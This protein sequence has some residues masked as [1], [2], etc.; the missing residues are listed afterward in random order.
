MTFQRRIKKLL[1]TLFLPVTPFV[2]IAVLSIIYLIWAFLIVFTSGPTAALI[3][4]IAGAITV[5]VLGLYVLD[6]IMVKRLS[7]RKL[8]LSEIFLGI[9]IVL[10]FYLT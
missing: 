4:A 3:G 10:W 6:R 2:V 7:Y 5:M 1:R 9:L 8:V